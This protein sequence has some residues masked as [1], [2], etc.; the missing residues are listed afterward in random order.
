[1]VLLGALERAQDESE[2]APRLLLK[3]GV[4]IELRLG[5]QARATKDLDLV[6]HGSLESLLEDLDAAFAAPYSDFYFRRS[7]PE[8]IRDTGS[9]RLQVKLLYTE[10]LKAWQTMQ[11]EASPAEGELAESEEIRALEIDDF[12]LEGPDRIQCLS[13]RYQIAQKLHACSERFPDKENDR[14]RDLID[15]ILLRDLVEDLVGV[16]E[17]CVK[18]FAHRKKHRWPPELDIEPSWPDIYAGEVEKYGFY[19]ATVGE[20]VEQVRDFIAEIDAAR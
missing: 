1:M 8:L 18:T 3:G 11:V 6:F 15:L 10:K 5:L 14:S 4:A 7:E 13:L 17:A 2:G 12:G 19:V 16:R 9:Y 20:A